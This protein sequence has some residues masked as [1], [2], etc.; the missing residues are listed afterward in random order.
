MERRQS[1]TISSDLPA[2]ARV[3]AVL[4]GLIESGEIATGAKLPTQEEL[5]RKFNV[6]RITITRALQDLEAEGIVERR[7]GVGTFVR[8]P[9]STG[10]LT[11]IEQLYKQTFA[12]DSAPTHEIVAIDS[13]DEHPERLGGGL[14]GAGRLLKVTRLRVLEGALAG[15]EESFITARVVSHDDSVRDLEHMLLF[16]F[17]TKECGIRLSATRVHMA[18]TTLDHEIAAQLKTVAGAPALLLTRVT[19]DTNDRP[20]T[21]SFNTLPAQLSSYYFE[22]RHGDQ[23]ET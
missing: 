8:S 19:Y 1:L 10:V 16:D 6:S 22:F 21:I 13:V 5:C 15:Y 7:Q 14:A 17:L 3:K 23:S 2:Y 11:S 20:V 12:G 9:I 18:A 4:R